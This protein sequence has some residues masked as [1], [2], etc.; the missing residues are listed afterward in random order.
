M[1]KRGKTR[2]GLE[3]HVTT[4]EKGV[5][6]VNGIDLDYTTDQVYLHAGIDPA[7]WTGNIRPIIQWLVDG[8]DPEQIIDAIMRVARRSEYVTPGSL[9]YFDK[10]VRSEKPAFYAIGQWPEPTKASA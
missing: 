6:W 2:V 9:N 3:E 7:N 5:Q 1:P 8:Y 10:P 4:D